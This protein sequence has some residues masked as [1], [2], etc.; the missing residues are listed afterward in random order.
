M[1]SHTRGFK[2]L[3][4]DVCAAKTLTSIARLND[5]EYALALPPDWRIVY[6]KLDKKPKFWCD[7]CW[8]TFE[9]TLEESSDSIKPV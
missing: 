2:R 1:D 3:T 4:C 5:D 7:V 8:S 6:S 9:L